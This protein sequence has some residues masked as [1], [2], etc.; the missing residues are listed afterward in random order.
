MLPSRKCVKIS[1]QQVI[2]T[3]LLTAGNVETALRRA[4][5]RFQISLEE[6]PFSG[7]AVSC[8]TVFVI[9]YRFR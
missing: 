2:G 6:I 8:G 1:R 5:L 9:T 7:F 4:N 3:S